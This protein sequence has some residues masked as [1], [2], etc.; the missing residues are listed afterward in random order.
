TS[1]NIADDYFKEIE[2]NNHLLH[3]LE[4]ATGDSSKNMEALAEAAAIQAANDS[5]EQKHAKEL[6]IM[7]E[8]LAEITLQKDVAEANLLKMAD[9]LKEAQDALVEKDKIIEENT[10]QIEKIQEELI[11]KIAKINHLKSV[12]HKSKK[13]ANNSSV[14]VA[15]ED[16][17]TY[18]ELP[19]SVINEK[20]Q[21]KTKRH[22]SSFR[23]PHKNK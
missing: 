21:E 6:E 11:A 9:T 1:I 3:E 13:P 23:L 14:T 10:T 17:D 20:P 22:K 12:E 4:L 7:E 18:K 19:V 5:L 8:R 2:K 15:E 16:N